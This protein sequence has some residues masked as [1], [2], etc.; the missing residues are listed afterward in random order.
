MPFDME[1]VW[2]H[3]ISKKQSQKQYFDKSH[4]MKP[5][6]QLNPGQEVLFLLPADHQS[7]IPGT[8]IDKASTPWNYTI[9]A[10][11]IQYHRTRIT[12]TPLNMI[13]S[14]GKLCITQ[15][16][17]KALSQATS[18]NPQSPTLEPTLSPITHTPKHAVPRVQ[19][20]SF[21]TCWPDPTTSP[22]TPT[23]M[24]DLLLS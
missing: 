11:G 1:A 10:Q 14:L 22:S 21:H 24:V 13:S 2:N 15:S 23:A 16:H 17:L 8:I 5:L 7:Y 20:A 19:P 4:N 18:L 9:E 3:L 6:S 12:S